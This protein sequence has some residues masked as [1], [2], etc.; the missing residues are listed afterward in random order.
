MEEIKPISLI[1]KSVSLKNIRQK[2]SRI[3]PYD[4]TVLITGETGVGKEIVAKRI[5]NLSSRKNEKFA[6]INVGAIPNNLLES[7][8]FG[9]ERGAFTGANKR[10]IGRLEVADKGSFFMDEIAELPLHLQVKL[11]RAIQNQTFQR[12]GSVDTIKVDVRFIASTN[13]NLEKMIKKRKFREDLYFRLNVINIRIPPLRERKEDIPI[14]IKYFLKQQLGFLPEIEQEVYNYLQ[15]FNWYGNVRELI[16]NLRRISIFLENKSNINLDDVKP[17]VKT[18]NLKN[19][20]EKNG[21][22]YWKVP[23]KKAVE[24]FK[25]KY[26]IRMLKK[27]NWTQTETAKEMNIQPSYL[28]RLIKK[29]N[30]KRE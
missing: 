3:A 21:E 11:L 15:S 18:A 7:E 13:R 4:A 12:L 6:P 30:I 24:K 17:Y 9:Y 16:N 2:V 20:D 1:G 25:K 8:L 28:S 22:K 29:Y 14:L 26:I 27:H 5:H 19:P 10:K 23:Y